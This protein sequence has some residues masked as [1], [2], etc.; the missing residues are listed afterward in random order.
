[1]KYITQTLSLIVVSISLYYAQLY[2][3]IFLFTLFMIAFTYLHPALTLFC[4]AYREKW[5]IPVNY[6]QLVLAGVFAVFNMLYILKD[7][8]LRIFYGLGV[9]LTFIATLYII[10]KKK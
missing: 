10:T 3:I 4:R 8:P 7:A 1:M 9:G 5:N 2:F 6:G